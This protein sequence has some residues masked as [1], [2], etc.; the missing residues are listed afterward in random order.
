VQ[1]WVRED[2]AAGLVEPTGKFGM[3]KWRGGL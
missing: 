3:W 2:E 1:R